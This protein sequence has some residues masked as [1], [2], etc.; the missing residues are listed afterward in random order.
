VVSGLTLA[1]NW[2]V[3]STPEVVELLLRGQLNLRRVALYEDGHLGDHGPTTTWA[4]GRSIAVQ[5]HGDLLLN[6]HTQYFQKLPR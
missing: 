5:R 4:V 2:G 3:E 6:P 1:P